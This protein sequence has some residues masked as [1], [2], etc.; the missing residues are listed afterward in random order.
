MLPQAAG[1][2]AWRKAL[3]SN[4]LI[5]TVESFFTLISPTW[6]IKITLSGTYTLRYFHSA[7]VWYA[8]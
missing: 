5:R 8:I 6:M 2:F 3:F 1:S 7:K 4:F